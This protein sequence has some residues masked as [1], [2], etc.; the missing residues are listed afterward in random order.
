MMSA[1]KDDKRDGKAPSLFS[2]WDHERIREAV[3]QVEG[4]AGM[5]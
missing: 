2:Y 5:S 1:D 3:L 4:M